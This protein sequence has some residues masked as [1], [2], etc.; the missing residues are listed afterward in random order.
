MTN[1]N[2]VTQPWQKSTMN[3]VWHGEDRSPFWA[4]DWS[5]PR[6]TDSLHGHDETTS[7]EVRL[8]QE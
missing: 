7:V 6:R 8:G 1:Q 3:P 4:S 5:Q 2:A